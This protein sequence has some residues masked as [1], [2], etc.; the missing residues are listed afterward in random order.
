MERF[1]A[2][3]SQGTAAEASKALNELGMMVTAKAIDRGTPA[4][5]IL[6]PIASAI[7]TRWPVDQVD[8]ERMK[9]LEI[10]NSMAGGKTREAVVNLLLD[11]FDEKL[12]CHAELGKHFETLECR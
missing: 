2:K 6:T 10:R 12:R 5:E 9:L 11:L 8:R 1:L 4:A 7:V 3:L